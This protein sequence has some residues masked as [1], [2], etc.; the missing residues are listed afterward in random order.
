M[1]IHKTFNAHSTVYIDHMYSTVYIED[2]E[3]LKFFLREHTHINC[4]ANMRNSIAFT[5]DGVQI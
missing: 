4:Q 1:K 2:N 3:E 5:K